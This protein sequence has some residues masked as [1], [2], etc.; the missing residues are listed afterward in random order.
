MKHLQS[1][2][3]SLFSLR[4]LTR[5]H[6]P[7]LL[8][9]LLFS[10][11]G[12]LVGDDDCGCTPR[13]SFRAMQ[14]GRERRTDEGHFLIFLF[15]SLSFLFVIYLTTK[16]VDQ[17]FPYDSCEGPSFPFLPSHHKGLRRLSH[18]PEKRSR[19]SCKKAS[20]EH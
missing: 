7:L 9:L 18:L 13:S 16:E 2:P 3:P 6:P 5:L 14:E 19:K 8:R 12:C 20:P 17:T 10:F 15:L 1:H 11:G 4:D